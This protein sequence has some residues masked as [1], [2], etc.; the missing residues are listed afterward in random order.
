M[1]EKYL[2]YLRSIDSDIRREAIIALGKSGDPRAL[3]ALAYVYQTDPDPALR[4]LAAKAGRYIQRTAPNRP[5]D[6]SAPA[7]SPDS[8]WPGWASPGGKPDAPPPPWQPSWQAALTRQEEAPTEP[9]SFEEPEPVRYVSPQRR[10]IGRGQLNQAFTYMTIGDEERALAELAK[11]VGTDPALASDQSART[12]AADLMGEAPQKAMAALLKKIEAGEFDSS[13][14]VRFPLFAEFNRRMLVLVIEV[15]LLFF[16]LMLFIIA[17]SFRIRNSVTMPDMDFILPSLLSSINGSL[18]ERAIPI[19]FASVVSVLFFVCIVYVVGIFAG[20]TG[21]FFR[22]LTTMIGVQIM[23]CTIMGIGML[24]VPFVVAVPTGE[25]GQYLAKLNLGWTFIG[26]L[27]ML[28]AESYFAGRAHNFDLHKGGMI[29]IVGA[30]ATSIL[31]G[32]FGL[33]RG[34]IFG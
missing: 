11:A 13:R 18:L 24:V 19:T 15:P 3:S 4:E 30:A 14:P 17:Y 34:S 25:P 20:G 22:F 1:F 16:G 9:E 31:G 7:P 8:L 32:F 28:I 12:L 6:G 21:P 10:Q 27:W 33:F 5:A 26:G 23:V 29:I 2:Q